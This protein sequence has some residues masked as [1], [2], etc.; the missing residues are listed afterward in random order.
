MMTRGTP[1]VARGIALFPVL[2]YFVAV[3]LDRFRPLWRG[4]RRFAVPVV[5]VA[6]ALAAAA[7]DGHLYYRWTA[8]PHTLG[9][10]H[11]DVRLDEF[12]EWVQ[13]QYLS[14]AKRGGTRNIGEWRNLREHAP[15]GE[16]VRREAGVSVAPPAER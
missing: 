10:R 6:F 14:L 13:W 16:L 5:L 7:Y 1:D 4:S 12:P 11:P 15:A 2:Y 8:S 9:Q 3:G